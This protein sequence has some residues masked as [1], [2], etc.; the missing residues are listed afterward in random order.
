MGQDVLNP[1]L[2]EQRTHRI[3]LA[4]LLRQLKLPEDPSAAGRPN[5]QRA[6]AQSMRTNAHGGHAQA[7]PDR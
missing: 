7:S 4:T 1:L 2:V 3:T 5:Q 6:A